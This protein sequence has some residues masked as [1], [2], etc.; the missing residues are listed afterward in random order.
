M[1]LYG[2]TWCRDGVLVSAMV[3]WYDIDSFRKHPSRMCRTRIDGIA[4]LVV[5]GAD[6]DGVALSAV[7]FLEGGP[8]TDLGQPLLLRILGPRKSD[9]PLLRTIVSAAR[10]PQVKADQ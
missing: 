7:Y 4:T 5:E 6:E 1:I 9:L 3:G 2:D 8:G 10:R